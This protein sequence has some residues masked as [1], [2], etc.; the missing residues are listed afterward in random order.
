[1]AVDTMAT[2]KVQN[3]WYISDHGGFKLHFLSLSFVLCYLFI[4][5]LLVYY[6][7]Y[8][9]HFYSFFIFLFLIFRSH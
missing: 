4:Y 5:N 3:W 1:M 8:I 7:S 9:L 6:F 2:M